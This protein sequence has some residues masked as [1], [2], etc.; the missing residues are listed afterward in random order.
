MSPQEAAAYHR[1][2]IET[3]RETAADLV[4]ALTMT[5]AGEAV[6]VAIAA[7]GAEMPLALSF[8][9]ETDGRLPSG[10]RLGDAI[11]EVDERCG[12][13]RPAYYMITCAHPTHFASELVTNEPWAER[14]RGIRANAS[15]KSHA[16]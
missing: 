15:E 6:G 7:A 8:T 16:E 4:S 2:Q 9:V 14:I 1:P 12:A 10:Q 3:F 11:E 5:H 13:D